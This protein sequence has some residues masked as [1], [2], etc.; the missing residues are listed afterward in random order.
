MSI[1]GPTEVYANR[2]CRA[3]CA[4]DQQH[5][6]WRNTYRPF[7]IEM[8]ADVGGYCL[9]APEQL[10]GGSVRSYGKGAPFAAATL[11]QRP[12]CDPAEQARRDALAEQLIAEILAEEASN[13]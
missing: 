12:D 11:I 13:K 8:L 5:F 7:G 3:W 4:L 2:T 9:D 10:P 6:E 1:L